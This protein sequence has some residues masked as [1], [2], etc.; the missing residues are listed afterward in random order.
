VKR[1]S[2]G[3]FADEWQHPAGLGLV[4]FG[5]QPNRALDAVVVAPLACVPARSHGVPRGFQGL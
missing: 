1:L 2:P 5:P 3:Q 4:A